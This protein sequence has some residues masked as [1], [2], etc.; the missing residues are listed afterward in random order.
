MSRLG[1]RGMLAGGFLT[2]PVGQARVRLPH[3]LTGPVSFKLSVVAC[4]DATAL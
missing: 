4:R 3:S 1:L 2:L